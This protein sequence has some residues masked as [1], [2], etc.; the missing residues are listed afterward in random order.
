MILVDSFLLVRRSIHAHFLVFS[1]LQSQQSVLELRKSLLLLRGQ[2]PQETEWG[3]PER[4][5]MWTNTIF[6][7]LPKLVLKNNLVWLI[8]TI[9]WV[10]SGQ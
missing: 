9:T 8:F 10:L 5:P 4:N 1:A 2:V 7:F 6:Q 3:P